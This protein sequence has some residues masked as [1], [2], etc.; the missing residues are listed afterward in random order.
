MGVFSYMTR[1]M[2]NS[3]SLD[4][5]LSG[6]GMTVAVKGAVLAMTTV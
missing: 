4:S 2:T 6:N 5:H 3:L 1:V